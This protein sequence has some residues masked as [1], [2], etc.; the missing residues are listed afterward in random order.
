MA[1][2]SSRG[3]KKSLFILISVVCHFKKLDI[4]VQYFACEVADVQFELPLAHAFR[5]NER[6]GI[7]ISCLHIPVINMHGV[8]KG[9]SQELTF[10]YVFQC[11]T[12]QELLLD[13]D[14]NEEEGLNEEDF[15]RICPAL[16]QQLQDKACIVDNLEDNHMAEDS[17]KMLHGKI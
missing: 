13:H 15:V 6:N 12:G 2:Y 11:L 10:A 14:V 7:K 1:C 9:M 16:I 8:F 3:K 5:I 4:V 17:A